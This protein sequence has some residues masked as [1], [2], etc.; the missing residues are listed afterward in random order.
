MPAGDEA[1]R[2][3]RIAAATDDLDKTLNKLFAIAA[4]LKTILAGRAEPDAPSTPEGGGGA[5]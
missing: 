2:L 1:Q 3:A 4:E 5:R